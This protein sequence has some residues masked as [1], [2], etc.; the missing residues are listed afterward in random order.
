MCNGDVACGPCSVVKKGMGDG[1]GA[2]RKNPGTPGW[3]TAEYPEADDNADAYLDAQ[4]D[5]GQGEMPGNNP[6]N[7]QE[8]F[9]EYMLEQEQMP[10]EP[11]LSGHPLTSP[12]LAGKLRPQRG[13][14]DYIREKG[15]RRSNPN[16]H[17]E[18]AEGGVF[19]ENPMQQYRQRQRGF[20]EDILQPRGAG[21]AAQALNDSSI[22]RKV[23]SMQKAHILGS[24]PEV[25]AEYLETNPNNYNKFPGP[26]T[27]EDHEKQPLFNYTAKPGVQFDPKDYQPDSDPMPYRSFTKSVNNVSSLHKAF[28]GG[29]GILKL[30][31]GEDEGSKPGKTNPANYKRYD[32]PEKGSAE[33]NARHATNAMEWVDLPKSRDKSP[34]VKT[35]GPTSERARH[36]ARSDAEERLSASATEYEHQRGGKGP[37]AFGDKLKQIRAGKA[38]SAM[39]KTLVTEAE[40]F[41]DLGAEL[42]PRPLDVKKWTGETVY[43]KATEQKRIESLRKQALVSKEFKAEGPSKCKDCGKH[44]SYCGC[45]MQKAIRKEDEDSDPD[46]PKRSGKPTPPRDEDNPKDED[47]PFGEGKPEGAAHTAFD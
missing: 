35:P 25:V 8:Q 37:D 23:R 9:N 44:K 40:H 31:F 7:D 11:D 15:G 13:E 43:D 4:A 20:S 1:G 17:Q 2:K 36:K 14:Q 6:L 42:N 12:V 10:V 27:G 29:S 28:F 39:R 47:S 24:D 21:L 45:S 22:M 5:A 32:A 3:L 38:L 26:E 33:V 18:L 19:A 16:Y 46:S 34:G 30:R 41:T